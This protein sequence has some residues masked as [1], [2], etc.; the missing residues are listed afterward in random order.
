ML[1]RSSAVMILSGKVYFQKALVEIFSPKLCFLFVFFLFLFFFCGTRSGKSILFYEI[2]RRS[3][4]E[5][6]TIT[7]T[8]RANVKTCKTTT[9]MLKIL[10]SIR[11]TNHCFNILE[12]LQSRYILSYILEIVLKLSLQTCHHFNSSEVYSGSGFDG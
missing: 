9:I 7:T 6:K 1:P 10:V 11:W 5:V 2:Y 8:Y 12:I 4:Y 3:K